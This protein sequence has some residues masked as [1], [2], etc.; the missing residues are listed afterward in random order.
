MTREKARGR[1]SLVYLWSK[2][3]VLLCIVKYLKIGIYEISALA[4]ILFATLLRVLLAAL[5]WPYST[6]DEG[7]MGIMAM[8]IAYRGE[9]PIFWYGQHY[10]GT[11]EA[12]LAAALFHVFGVSVFTLRLSSII[13][14]VLFMVA[15]YFLTGVLYTKRW[16]VAT[17]IVLSLGSN[18]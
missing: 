4:I 15:M 8:H 14:Y 18:P 9:H 16:A 6:S 3:G 13:L 1:M 12:Y 10:M 5:N 17:L 11:L 7:T 2:Q